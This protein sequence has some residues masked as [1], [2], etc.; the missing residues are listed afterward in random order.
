MKIIDL[1]CDALM[2]LADGK[3]SLSYADSKEL[4]TNKARL[5]KGETF[6]QCFAIFIDLDIKSDQKFQAALDQIY[7]FKNEVLGKNH[8]MK[9]IT[10][11]EDFDQLKENEIGAMLTLEGVDAIGNDIQKY[12]IL[13]EL[14]VLS[15][16]LTWNNANLAADGAG[17]PRGAGLTSFGKELVQFNNQH[18]ILTDV[19]HL[20]EKAFWD[21]MEIAKYPI[22]SHSNSKVLCNHV[23]NLTDQQ[24]RAMFDKGGLIHVVFN[25]PFINE[26]GQASISDLIKHMDHFCSLG[27]V[28]QIGF[29][30]DF[31]GISTKISK[32]E[33]SSM[34][35]NLINELLKY[36]SEEQVQGFAYQN[37]LNHR[38]E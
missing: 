13:H 29:G 8:E 12:S 21:V 15:V 16:G 33:N 14:G 35:Q 7:Y 31:D 1:H 34:Y 23:R 24:A 38:P 37:F 6:V 32:L 25:P 36:Y 27:G 5:Q 28:E 30:S 4:D 2:K 19:S 17:E 10:K 11:W 26:S 18:K 9:Q 3:G 20:C 22:A